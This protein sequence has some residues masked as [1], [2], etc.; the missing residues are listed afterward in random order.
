MAQAVFNCDVYLPRI[1]YLR[2]PALLHTAVKQAELLA[3]VDSRATENFVSPD[4]IKQ[5]NL[6][7]TKLRIPRRLHNVD[8]SK[9]SIGRITEYMDLEVQT[10][11][12]S[13]IHRF[14]ITELG[15]DSLILGYP[16]LAAANPRPDWAKGTLDTSIVVKTLG[17]ALLCPR[18]ATKIAGLRISTPSSP[19]LLKEGDELHI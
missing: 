10:G 12:L 14:F 17:A 8:G 15:E 13:Q 1:K 6:G 19:A 11:G 16:W 4:F 2:I 3:F 5:H 9:N 18:P 7:T